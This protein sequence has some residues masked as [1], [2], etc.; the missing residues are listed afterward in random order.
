MHKYFNN[1]YK[2][3]NIHPY[4]LKNIL[5]VKVTKFMESVAEDVFIL[6]IGKSG[7]GKS[8]LINLI[9]KELKSDQHPIIQVKSRCTISQ[10]MDINNKKRLHLIEAP[11]FELL[12]DAAWNIKEFLKSYP[13]LHW[14]VVAFKADKL[15]K[16]NTRVLSDIS[17]LFFLSEPEISKNII[18]CL[19]HTEGWNSVKRNAFH[20]QLLKTE[21]LEKLTARGAIITVFSGAPDPDEMETEEDR[22]YA[23]SKEAALHGKLTTIFAQPKKSFLE[24]LISKWRTKEAHLI[25]VSNSKDDNDKC[26][27]F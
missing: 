21:A 11:G 1:K 20:E 15:T 6:F 26:F 3:F 7:H 16:E 24:P 17:D 10:V 2:Q 8:R 4:H 25:A 18:I 5:L 9:M 23:M 12:S 22:R 14:I 27:L 19:T 13:G